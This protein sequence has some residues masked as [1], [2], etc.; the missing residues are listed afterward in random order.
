MAALPCPTTVTRTRCTSGGSITTTATTRTTAH[1]FAVTAHVFAVTAPTPGR[2]RGFPAPGVGGGVNAGH[3]ILSCLLCVVQWVVTASA[4][5]DRVV[6]VVD[7]TG[8]V[9]GAVQLAA[10]VA[11]GRRLGHIVWA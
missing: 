4:V 1:V 11:K 2:R 10:V 6:V 7:L 5:V 8:L 9:K 3:G